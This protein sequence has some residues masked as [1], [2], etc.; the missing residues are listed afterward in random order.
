VALR[1]PNTGSLQTQLARAAE[2]ARDPSDLAR[3][4]WAYLDVRDGARAFALAVE[5]DLPGCHVINVMAPDTL[6]PEPTV[7]LLARFHPTSELRR[8]MVGREVPFD[9]T[10]SGGLLGFS[11]AHR[12]PE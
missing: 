12:L 7:D 4:L 5:R 6:S 3:E 9:L 11:A 8:P 1:I 10:R 2:V